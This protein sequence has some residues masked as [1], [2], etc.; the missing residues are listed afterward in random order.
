MKLVLGDCL[1]EMKNIPEDVF[2]NTRMH[3]NRVR[4]AALLPLLQRFVDTGDL[5]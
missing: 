1:E 4:A 2:I 3:L 5:T